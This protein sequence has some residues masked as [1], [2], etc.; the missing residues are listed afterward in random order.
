MAQTNLCIP[1]SCWWLGTGWGLPV[2]DGKRATHGLADVGWVR[3]PGTL[4]PH[5]LLPPHIEKGAGTGGN[6]V[7]MDI[8]AYRLPHPS[9]ILLRN[10]IHRVVRLCSHFFV[11]RLRCR[12]NPLHFWCVHVRVVFLCPFG[13]ERGISPVQ[14]KR[15]A[16]PFSEVRVAVQRGR[17]DPDPGPPPVVRWQASSPD[18][19]SRG[20][21]VD[22]R[23]LKTRIRIA[24]VV[25]WV[26]AQ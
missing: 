6:F 3:D 15:K 14:E 18:R 16:A 8:A 21:L 23:P 11:I 26:V 4:R 22:P 7:T 25:G 20:L 17:G 10:S 2:W 9:S 1:C 5:P 24:A 13:V 19:L 12:D